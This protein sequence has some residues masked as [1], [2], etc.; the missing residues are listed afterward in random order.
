MYQEQEIVTISFFRYKGLQ[1]LWWA[2]TQMGKLP[3]LLGKIEGLSFVKMLGSGGKQGFSI[4][5]NFSLYGLLC[6]WENE[7]S[8]Q[9]FFGESEIFK[10]LQSKSEKYQTLF[11]QSLQAHGKWDGKEPFSYVRQSPQTKEKIAVITRAKIKWSKVWKFW[12]SV[13]PASR[14]MHTHPG[15]IFSVGIGELPL[16]QQATFSIWES[17]EAMTNYAYKSPQHKKVIQLT[18][19]SK[20]YQEELFARFRIR[21]TEGNGIIELD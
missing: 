18:Q 16:I 4:L 13:A 6:V 17:I 19:Q 14:K 10:K 21:H 12:S 20:W 2:F 3:Y 7:Q 15:L 8:C 11:L 1:N 5:P 9:S